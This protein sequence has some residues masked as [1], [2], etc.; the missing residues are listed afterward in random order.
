M[1]KQ[2]MEITEGKIRLIKDLQP[3]SNNQTQVG[4]TEIKDKDGSHSTHS[5]QITPIKTVDSN[6]LSDPK[7]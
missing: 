3:L 5:L 2:S 1:I 4:V 6:G 7:I